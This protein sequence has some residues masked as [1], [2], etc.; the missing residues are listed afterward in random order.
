MFPAISKQVLSNEEDLS[1]MEGIMRRLSVDRLKNTVGLPPDS[2][3]A[4][5]VFIC[6]GT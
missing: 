4:A 1:H 2:Y 6:Q 5:Q 3:D